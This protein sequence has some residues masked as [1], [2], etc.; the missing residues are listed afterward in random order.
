MLTLQWAS[1]KEKYFWKRDPECK[2]FKTR[3]VVRDSLQTRALVS[4]PGSGN[5]WTR[6][7]V[8]A[9]T[10]VF[11]GSFYHNKGIINK[12]LY[13]EAREYSDGSTLL[14][15]THHAM[16]QSKIFKLEWR[17]DHIRKFGGRAVLVVRNPY[18]AI[19]SFYN[20]YQT[21]SQKKSVSAER[22]QSKDFHNFVRDGAE[23]WLELIQDWLLFST[24][25]HV[26]MYEVSSEKLSQAIF[27][28]C[29]I[30]RI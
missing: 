13:G 11:T 20:F 5:T 16:P 12:G 26:V 18:K 6:Y 2:E 3:F 23:R 8:E 27:P 17:L 28:F 14:Q 30:F 21:G 29:L 10:G 9:A 15:K 1:G 19:I 22:L 25:L 24:D 4:Y 7:L